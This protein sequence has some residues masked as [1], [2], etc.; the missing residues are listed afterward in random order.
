MRQVYAQYS[1]Y[2]LA[3]HKGYATLKHRRAILEMG[4]SPIHRKTFAVKA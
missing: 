3:N 4:F 1:F 2:G